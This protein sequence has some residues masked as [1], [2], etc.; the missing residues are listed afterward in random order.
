M[1]SDWHR[2]KESTVLI[3]TKQAHHGLFDLLQRGEESWS[4]GVGDARRDGDEKVDI[5]WQF[6]GERYVIGRSG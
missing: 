4:I 6:D 5:T 1:A 3:V 2:A